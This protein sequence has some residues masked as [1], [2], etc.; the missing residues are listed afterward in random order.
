MG[1]GDWLSKKGLEARARGVKHKE[2]KERKC[3]YCVIFTISFAIILVFLGLY[4]DRT[5]NAGRINA[6]F[7]EFEFIA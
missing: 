7:T 5:A 6:E 3:A 1:I 2:T 4:A